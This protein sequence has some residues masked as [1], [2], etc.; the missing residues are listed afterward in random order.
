MS[1][2]PFQT[3]TNQHRTYRTIVIST[4][5]TVTEPEY[6]AKLNSMK[7][8]A[9]FN[10]VPNYGNGSDPRA[11]LARMKNHLKEYPLK[12]DD[13]AWIV[14]DQDEWTAESIKKVSDWASVSNRHY[15]VSIRRFEDWLKLHVVGDKASEK[16]YHSFLLG[17]DKHIPDDFL[18]KSR[19]LT[20]IAT[21]K[22]LHPTVKDVGNVFE[23]LESF[24]K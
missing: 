4:E 23:V 22:R 11:V 16:K 3:P 15:A 2:W 9:I 8:D 17:K 13:E 19:I 14:I 12:E 20:A 1:Q 5:G 6:F 21:A 7:K 18:T 10:M 24:F